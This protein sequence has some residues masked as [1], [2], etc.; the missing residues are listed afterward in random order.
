ML[1]LLLV[2]EVVVVVPF[3]I[4][5][6]L[7]GAGQL[8]AKIDERGGDGGAH[9]EWVSLDVRSTRALGVV[10]GIHSRLTSCHA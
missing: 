5:Q 4:K 9:A 3:A 1:L 7:D 10:T 6:V 8:Q 2:V